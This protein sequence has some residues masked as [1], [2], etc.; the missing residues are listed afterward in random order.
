MHHFLCCRFSK[1]LWPWETHR[2]KGA[3]RLLSAS[4]PI[5]FVRWHLFLLL[6]EF[7]CLAFGNMRNHSLV[8]QVKLIASHRYLN[9]FFTLVPI[10]V[11]CFV[12]L[13]FASIFHGYVTLLQH[14]NWR[15]LGYRHR[16]RRRSLLLRCSPLHL[17]LHHLLRRSAKKFGMHS[18][19]FT[20]SQPHKTNSL[21]AHLIIVTVIWVIVSFFHAVT[22]NLLTIQ[23]SFF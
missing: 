18:L 10:H 17:L 22:G 14:E 13:L 1:V 20:Y 12:T 7:F 9:L 11:I 15:I 3:P 4:S 5:Q 6:S 8:T 16:I 21:C 19:P 23:V 2:G